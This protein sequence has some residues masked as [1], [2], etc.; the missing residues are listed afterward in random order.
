MS[1]DTTA[2]TST[3]LSAAED[4]LACLSLYRH[5]DDRA[6]ETA[7]LDGWPAEAR[8]VLEVGPAEARLV[9]AVKGQPLEVR[10]AVASRLATGVAE[11]PD[12]LAA[13]LAACQVGCFVEEGMDPA[14]LG[15]ALRARLPGDFAAARRFVGLLEAET[16]VKCP[17]DADTATLARIG[18]KECTGASAWAALEFTTPAAM[19]AWCRHRP[20]RLAAKAVPGLADDAAFL[21]SRGG[22]CWYI[23]E[24]LSAA[25]G[26]RL[27]VLAPEQRK[28]FV[29]ELEVVRNA[30][31]LFALLEDA[32]VGDPGQ[33]L[34]AG[35][36]TDP[37]VAAI[38]RAEAAMEE[39]MVFAVGWHYEY[40]WGLHPE[41]AA[42]ASGLHPLVA[43][44]IGV[45]AT[46]HDLPEFQ[47]RLVILMR[48]ARIG[49]RNCDVS[50]ISS[51]HDALRSRATVLRQLPAAEVD[52][53]C[54]DLRAG[55]EKLG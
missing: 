10:R 33:G 23:G 20:S 38:A 29:V 30:A 35:P 24:L 36:R 4:Y 2:A 31:H 49:S 22:Y 50:F 32:L 54:D 14:P 52:A 27:T 53:L 43:A 34:L 7:T 15:E 44:M 48:P 3:A 17:A 21:G 1:D 13:G 12:P 46:I 41:A 19:A 26:T 47:G 55:A 6:A 40:W 25:D 42:R 9:Q 16:D 51:L 28:G 18:R 37:K 45:E 11:L 5:G 39:A 8:L